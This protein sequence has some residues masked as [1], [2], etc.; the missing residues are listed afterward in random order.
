MKHPATEYMYC[1]TRIRSMEG[2]MCGREELARLLEIGRAEEILGAL[3]SQGFVLR[4]TGEGGPASPTGEDS[5][6]PAKEAA[7][8]AADVD[9][10]L[11]KALREA[12]EEVAHM[13]P[14]PGLTRYLQYPYDCHNLKTVLK[15]FSRGLE[16]APMLFDCGTVSPERLMR[17]VPEWMSGKGERAMREAYPSHL[18]KAALTMADRFPKERNPQMLDL[19]LDR[20]CYED[21]L[22]AAEENGCE[23]ASGLLQ[24]QVDLLNLMMMCRILRQKRPATAEELWKE[25]RLPG[26]L[27][28]PAL[29]REAL[30][31]GEDRLWEALAYSPYAAFAETVKENGYRLTAMEKA[32]DNALME[33][34]RQARYVPFGPEVPVAYLYG[35]EAEIKNLRILLS[36]RLAGLGTGEIRE[37][38]RESYV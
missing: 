1:T 19:V 38:L 14:F 10:M 31:K 20:A 35:V 33:R 17:L 6:G 37:R 13:L 27:L 8:R 15:C 24:T 5:T 4:R 21:M 28:D 16:P 25:A 30:L 9:A 32:A 11:G 26:G 22:A 29:F 2:R 23:Y 3:A 12:Y 34:V 18:A 36:G 7:V